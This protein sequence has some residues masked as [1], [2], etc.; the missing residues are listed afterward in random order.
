MSTSSGVSNVEGRRGHG[1][2]E[3]GCNLR[4]H[5]RGGVDGRLQGV[6]LEACR[7][8]MEASRLA[9]SEASAAAL[10]AVTAPTKA[11]ATLV[12]TS[13]GAI[14]AV[15]GRGAVIHPVIGAFR[16]HHALQ[17]VDGRLVRLVRKTRGQRALQHGSR[18][19]PPARPWWPGLLPTARNAARVVAEPEM[20][21]VCVCEP[22]R[23]AR[24][25]R[26][27]EKRSLP[28]RAASDYSTA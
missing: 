3:G 17:H 22:C 4:V 1:A 12:S 25:S 15:H 21:C 26:Q 20:V 14:L 23:A 2:Q 27:R 28:F 7:P 24:R 9:S 16:G 6:A 13:S 11:L 5:L 18:A 19:Q 8:E 10:P